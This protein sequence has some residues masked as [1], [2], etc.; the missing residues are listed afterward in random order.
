LYIRVKRN[1]AA[2]FNAY[3]RSCV[4]HGGIGAFWNSIPVGIADD[5]YVQ[6][7]ICF[8]WRPL[9]KGVPL[10]IPSLNDAPWTCSLSTVEKY[11]DCSAPENADLVHTN[12]LIKRREEKKTK[13][14]KRSEKE[15]EGAHW[16]GLRA[17]AYL[18]WEGSS[19]WHYGIIDDY[20]EETN[21][22]K[23]LY[24]N[25]TFAWANKSA[26]QLAD[27]SE[28]DG[29][30]TQSDEES[31]SSEPE[32]A[33]DGNKKVKKEK[34][35]GAKKKRTPKEKGKKKEKKE[36]HKKKKRKTSKL[37][38]EVVE[39]AIVFDLNEESHENQVSIVRQK[40]LNSA[41]KNLEALY[42]KVKD[43]CTAEGEVPLEKYDELKI[44]KIGKELRN[45]LNYVLA[46]F[47]GTTDD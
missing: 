19:K 27:K 30:S 32:T 4:P 24:D 31:S 22:Y 13:K 23:I 2:A 44:H 10:A 42:L 41:Y 38:G 17:K 35:G 40:H 15:E 6:C 9:P 5:P 47:E 14:R 37:N 21:E 1:L 16:V 36:K 11:T 46:P 43:V 18:E 28:Q 20:D 26:F 33:E 34:K 29:N 45:D 7:T 3:W 25:G 39:N 12:R 8:K